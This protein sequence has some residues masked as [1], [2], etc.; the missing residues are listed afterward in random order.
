[1]L[2]YLILYQE[3]YDIL[4]KNKTDKEFDQSFVSDN[5]GQPALIFHLHTSHLENT[6]HK[7]K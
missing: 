6:K 5:R 1:M 4:L 3:K 2:L 7:N